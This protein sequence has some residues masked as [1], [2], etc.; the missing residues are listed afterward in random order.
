MTHSDDGGYIGPVQNPKQ[1][2]DFRHTGESTSLLPSY[3]D[4]AVNGDPPEDFQPKDPNNVLRPDQGAFTSETDYDKMLTVSKKA[5]ERY[6]NAAEV[7][8]EGVRQ[9]LYDEP[10]WSIDPNP[11]DPTPGDPGSFT[12]GSSS[13]PPPTSSSPSSMGSV[14]VLPDVGQRLA[15]AGGAIFAIAIGILAAMAWGIRDA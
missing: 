5:L 6:P 12:T 2:E 3:V 14:S 11:A 1:E 7:S 4:E 15:S 13:S 8:I 9:D 10:G